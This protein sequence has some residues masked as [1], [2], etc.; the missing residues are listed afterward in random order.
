MPRCGGVVSEAKNGYFC[1]SLDR[2]FGLWRDNKYLAAK[3]ISLTRSLAT[4]LLENGRA[5]LDEIYSPR[6]DKY[7]PGDLILHDDGEHAR[8]FLS[9][10]GGKK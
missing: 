7:Y 6:M 2:K 5:H 9:F 3:R 1:E 8:Y 4:E 10:G